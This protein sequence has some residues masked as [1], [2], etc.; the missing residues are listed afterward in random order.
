MGLN[1]KEETKFGV[2]LEYWNIK[3]VAYKKDL[4]MVDITLNG[5]LTKD[6]YN[7]GK[8][9]LVIDKTVSIDSNELLQALYDKIKEKNGWLD[10]SD[11]L[12]V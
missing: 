11:V 4:Q 5:Y 2:D 1:L 7:Q 12:E 10:S 9:P 6:A 3:E 8:S